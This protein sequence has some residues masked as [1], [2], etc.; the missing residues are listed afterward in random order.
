MN[1]PCQ[2]PEFRPFTSPEYVPASLFVYANWRVVPVTVMPSWSIKSTPE[3]VMSEARKTE[4]VR[5]DMKIV[6]RFIDEA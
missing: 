3:L 5:S 2:P 4:E 6:N 1:Q